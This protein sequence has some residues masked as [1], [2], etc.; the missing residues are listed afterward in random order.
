MIGASV[1]LGTSKGQS[2]DAG[3]PAECANVTF[4]SLVTQAGNSHLHSVM[5]PPVAGTLAERRK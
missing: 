3:A 5:T 1:G 4:R 2:R